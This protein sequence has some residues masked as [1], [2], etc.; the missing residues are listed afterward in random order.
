MLGALADASNRLWLSPIS[1]WEFM[2]LAERGRVRLEGSM[3]PDAWGEVAFRRAPLHDAPLNREVAIRSQSVGLE[4]DDPDD[5]F[6][7][8]TAAVY[9]LTLVTSDE[10]LLRGTG[11]QILAN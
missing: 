5:R 2:L 11:F 9:E 7:A 3:A 1:V 8:A 4:H 10:R 6:L